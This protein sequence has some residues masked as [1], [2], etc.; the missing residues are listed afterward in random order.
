M[1]GTLLRK[2]DHIVQICQTDTADQTLQNSSYQPLIS[3]RCV[4]ETERHLRH[5]V[6]ADMRNEC[7]FLDV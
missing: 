7:C 4:T 1:F 5:L 6:E 3:R 2:D